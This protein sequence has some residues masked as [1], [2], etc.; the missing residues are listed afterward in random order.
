MAKKKKLN[1]IRFDVK[2]PDRI[3]G[4]SNWNTGIASKLKFI[5]R[6][7]QFSTKLKKGL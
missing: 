6:T 3:Y 4:S 1:I 7:V 5:K 2:F